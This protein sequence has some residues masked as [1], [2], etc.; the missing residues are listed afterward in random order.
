M[1]GVSSSIVRPVARSEC[2]SAQVIAPSDG[3]DVMPDMESMAASTASAPACAAASIDATP[4]QGNPE[5]TIAKMQDVRRAALAPAN[6]SAQDRRVAS[7]ATRFEQEARAQIAAQRA[8]RTPETDRGTETEEAIRPGQAQ[9]DRDAFAPVWDP[10]A[11]MA[12]SALLEATEPD[13]VSIES[14]IS[15]RDLDQPEG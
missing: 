1:S 6:P 2:C 12:F 7:E 4:V 11:A 14:T 3:C 9:D 8:E 5:A 13:P 10:R 15:A